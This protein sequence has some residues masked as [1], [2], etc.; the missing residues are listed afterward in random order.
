MKSILVKT[1]AEKEAIKEIDWKITAILQAGIQ[2]QNS[3]AYGLYVG[4][5]LLKI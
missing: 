5:G 4:I 3:L 1:T 2:R